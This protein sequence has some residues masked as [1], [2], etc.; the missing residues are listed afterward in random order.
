MEQFQACTGCGALVGN[1]DR[2]KDAHKDIHSRWMF[3][4]EPKQNH[5]PCIEQGK[6]YD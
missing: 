1:K 4:P 6:I 2:D 5:G 3:K